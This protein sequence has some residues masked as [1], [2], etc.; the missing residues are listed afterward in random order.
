MFTLVF[1]TIVFSI[2]TFVGFI[3]TWFWVDIAIQ[4]KPK[5]FTYTA[6]CIIFCA[7]IMACGIAGLLYTW[8]LL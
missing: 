7:L 2:I 5:P 8:K 6:Y 3:C 1:D 4:F